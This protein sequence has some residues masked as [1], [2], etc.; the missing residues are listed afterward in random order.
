M[1]ARHIIILHVIVLHDGN[2]NNICCQQAPHLF[3][4]ASHDGNN[5]QQRTISYPGAMLMTYH[6]ALHDGNGNNNSGNNR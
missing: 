5:E 4:I 1:Q 3:N 2:D 6:I